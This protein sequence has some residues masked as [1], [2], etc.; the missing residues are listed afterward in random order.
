M[1]G[2]PLLIGFAAETEDVV[3][4]RRRS[5]RETHRHH[6][7]QRRVAAG[8]VDVE[9]SAVTIVGPAD[10][11]LPLQSKSRVASEILD[12]V[13][14]DRGQS[15][16]SGTLPG[17]MNTVTSPVDGSVRLPAPASPGSDQ[18]TAR[19]GRSAEREGW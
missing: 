13:E 8:P 14:T 4:A 2:D 3:A 17:Q 12:R 11:V 9:A 10:A 19:P 16:W 1:A 6:R 18:A 15:G 7:R 5:A